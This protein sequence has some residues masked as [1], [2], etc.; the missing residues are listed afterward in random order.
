MVPL[1][2]APSSQRANL[3]MEDV[4]KQRQFFLRN[5]IDKIFLTP[6]A[7]ASFEHRRV[8]LRAVTDHSEN[9]LQTISRDGRTCVT[10]RDSS[11]LDVNNARDDVAS[12]AHIV[13]Y[14]RNWVVTFA[15]RVEIDFTEGQPESI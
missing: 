13:A 10:R 6:V 11:R 2:A 1:R 3:G 4:S 15:Q 9:F 5:F 12:M 14:Q 7:V 8:P